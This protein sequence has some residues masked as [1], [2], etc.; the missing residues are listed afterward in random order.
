MAAKKVARSSKL[1]GTLRVSAGFRAFAL[2]QLAQ[3]RDVTARS[4][5]GGIGLYHGDLFFGILA[6][7]TLYLKADNETREQFERA[8]SRP[9]TPFPDR[10]SSMHYYSVPAAILEDVDELT[11][12][13]AR[14]VAAA[15]RSATAKR[16]G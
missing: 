1:G 3:A 11:R 9:F 5:F 12:W 8:G 15:A 7:D 16:K 10:K 13:V 6:A 14:A 2:D 4:M